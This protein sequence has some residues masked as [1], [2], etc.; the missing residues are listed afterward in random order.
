MLF[1]LLTSQPLIKLLRFTVFNTFEFEGDEVGEIKK[2]IVYKTAG[3]GYERTPSRMDW[4]RKI[5]VY[6][7]SRPVGTSY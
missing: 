2:D 4:I 3:G 6:G 1:L 5:S 7:D